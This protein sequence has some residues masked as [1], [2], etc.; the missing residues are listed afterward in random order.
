MPAFSGIFHVISR[1]DNAELSCH[2]RSDMDDITEVKITYYP[3]ATPSPFP[4]AFESLRIGQ[5]YLI[6]GEFR[7]ENNE[8]KVYPLNEITDC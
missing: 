8:F 3:K 7:I 2:I 6:S 4:L 5:V 1:N